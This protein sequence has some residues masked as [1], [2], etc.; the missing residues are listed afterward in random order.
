MKSVSSIDFC[1]AAVECCSRLADALQ[2]APCSGTVHSV[3]RSSVNLEAGGQLI[4]LLR[5]DRPLYPW[6]VRLA[7]GALPPFREGMPFTADADGFLFP[8]LRCFI[9]LRDAPRTDCSLFSLAE[10]L[11]VP[12]AEQIAALRECIIRHGKPEGFA[13][14]LALLEEQELHFPSNLYA[15][16]AAKKL[17]ALFTAVAARDLPAAAEAAW[18]ITGC[19]IGLT[20]SADDFLCGVMAALLATAYAKGEA[21]KLLPLTRAM[22]ARAAPRTNR[23]SG[24]F[25]L[26]A[27][28]GLLSRDVLLLIQALYSRV[29]SQGLVASAINV[30]AFGETSGTDILTGIYFG[31]NIYPN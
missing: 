13:P 4:T 17:P 29:L 3:F 30:I 25:L 21:E 5:Q 19:G 12:A 23:I 15:D 8:T 6:S 2:S 10:P 27:G 1:P 31:Q 11:F 16:H 24:T 22:A 28:E 14:L 9:P 20:P 7:A 18:S 26:E